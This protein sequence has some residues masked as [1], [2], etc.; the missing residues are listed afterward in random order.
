MAA[1][2]YSQLTTANTFQHWLNATQYL[3]GVANTITNGNGDTFYANTRLEIGGVGASLNV[4]TSATIEDLHSNTINTVSLVVTNNIAQANVT[5]TLKV[6]N[7]AYVY[8]TLTVYGTTTLNTTLAVV[9]DA[10]IGGNLTVTGNITLDS[11]GFDDLIVS[12]SGSFGNTLNVTGVSTLSTA[13]VETLNANTNLTVK[14][15]ATLVVLGTTSTTGNVVS[16]NV[17]VQQVLV[18]N[19]FTGN[20]NTAI[21]AAIDSNKSEVEAT[22]LA[23][24]IALG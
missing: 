20:A 22:S 15:S 18:A 21:Y 1:N 23:F 2:T 10:T 5:E 19:I 12:G 16:Q 14:D 6:G 7:D 4:V 13:N 11:V 8:D 17:E 24:S 9:G 3:I